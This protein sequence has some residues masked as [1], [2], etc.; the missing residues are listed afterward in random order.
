MSKS[1]NKVSRRIKGEGTIRKRGN[2]YEG[3]VTVSVNGKNK[4]ISVYGKTQR[5][6]VEKM[7]E[8]RRQKD[9][10]YFIENNN[11]TLEEW[12]KEWMKIYKKPY[13]SPR[14]YQGYVEKTKKILSD[15]FKKQRK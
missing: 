15:F 13:I 14:T 1:N 10:N 4:Q 5:I 6:V 9:D 2:S 12:I 8:M 3:R 7:Q 11:V